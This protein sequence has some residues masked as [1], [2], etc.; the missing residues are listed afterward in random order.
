MATN[1]NQSGRILNSG[2]YR[3]KVLARSNSKHG[4]VKI[5]IPGVYPEEWENS[6][7]NLPDAEPAMP[8]F[9]GCNGG[10]GM[11]SYPNINSTV[12]CFFANNDQNM[13][14]YFAATYGGTD[15]A[16]Q[17]DTCAQLP[18]AVDGAYVH[19]IC[20]GKTTIILAETGN[21]IIETLA[22]DGK[23]KPQTV[24]INGDQS[25]NLKI[26]SSAC[27]DISTNE[28]RIRAFDKMSFASPRV[29]FNTMAGK[30]SE[31]TTYF[32]VNTN[33]MSVN[34]NN[35]NFEVDTTRGHSLI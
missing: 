31:D 33:S 34:T 22:L 11:F 16:G 2:F 35:G 21:F 7:E 8:L 26:N 17:F 6:P 30:T 24:T 19:K 27:I 13:P 18:S 9:A 1:G 29:E 3:G 20:A 32:I 25:G 28:M 10:N 23:N 4:R 14:V 5:W 12:W 15:A